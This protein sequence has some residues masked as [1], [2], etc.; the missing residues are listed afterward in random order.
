MN[1]RRAILVF[2]LIEF[3]ADSPR[4]C[5][6]VDLDKC[7]AHTL[8]LTFINAAEPLLCRQ[9]RLVTSSHRIDVFLVRLR[10][11]IQAQYILDLTKRFY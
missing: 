8:F 9:S 7:A 6:P 11:E 10:L 5:R 3:G 1:T 4:T 2:Y